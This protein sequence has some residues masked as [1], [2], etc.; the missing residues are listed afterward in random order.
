MIQLVTQHL[1]ERRGKKAEEEDG[2][3]EGKGRSRSTY[4]IVLSQKSFE[5]TSIGIESRSIQN[6]VSGLVEILTT[7]KERMKK[8]E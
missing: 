4:S 8:R 1:R 6:R 3:R 7:R 5:D 2:E